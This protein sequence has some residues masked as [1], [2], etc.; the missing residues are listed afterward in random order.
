MKDEINRLAASLRDDI[1]SFV[2]E[3]VA[4][5]SLSGEE[6]EVVER[7]R[8]EM[9]DIGYDEVRVDPMGNLLG[10]VGSGE[11]I[12]AIDGHCDTVDVGNPD[13]WEVDPFRGDYRDGVIYG[14]GAVDQKGGLAAAIYAGRIV[15][16]IGVPDG[17]SLLVV[18]SVYEEEVEGLSWQYIIK[19]E[20]IMPEAVLLTEPTGLKVSIGQ[21][22]R[23]EM[24]V[25]TQ[26]ISC[27]GSAPDRGQN[28]IYKIA[29]VV[30]EVERL[31]QRLEGDAIMGKGSVTVTD[32]RST[33]PCLCAVADGAT[34]HLDRRLTT[35]ETLETAMQQVENLPSVRAS[36][37]V[38]TVPEYEIKT[39]TG[40]VYPIKAYYPMWLMDR[41]D[42]LVEKAVETFAAQFGEEAEVGVWAFSTNGVTTKGAYDIPTIGFGP[43]QEEHAHT[44][45]DQV[46]VD[47]LVKA[48]EFYSAFVLNW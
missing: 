6:G 43:G 9:Q 45:R 14:R 40:F 5:P 11:R 36:E 22:G 37:A 47:D 32:I 39:H 13:T 28:A 33:A 16:E 25:R 1:A 2:R 10:R 8:Q 12:L 17:V 42:P 21:R 30:Q 41:S 44:P 18:A 7:L 35:G 46:R 27:H 38:V 15:R 48:M 24:K 4:I 19:E 3:I 20:G 34:I 29:P 23:M 26:G 31:H